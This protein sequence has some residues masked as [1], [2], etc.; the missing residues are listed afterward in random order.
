[1][2]LNIKSYG[3]TF[4]TSKPIEEGYISLNLEKVFN[5]EYNYTMQDIM[6]MTELLNPI[7]VLGYLE[8]N[9]ISNNYIEN[10]IN[11]V[12][13]SSNASIVINKNILSTVVKNENVVITATL[14]RNNIED[15]LY[16]NPE[17][18]IRLPSQIKQVD[19]K[20]AR[21]IYEDEL[22]PVTFHAEGNDIYLKLEGIQTKY[23]EIPNVKGTVIKI[24]ADLTL[25]NLAVN[26]EERNNITIHQ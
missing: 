14:E 7:D 13:P 18:L 24:V 25:D 10:K 22:V 11:L 12:E 8:K 5:T 9:Q 2:E 20:D 3:L 15:A 21:L 23:N 1:M 16:K 17:L 19:L 4:I 26:S 6:N